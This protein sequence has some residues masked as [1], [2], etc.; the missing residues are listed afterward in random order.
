MI[1]DPDLFTINHQGTNTIKNILSR[2]KYK[3][4]VHI[5]SIIIPNINPTTFV[6]SDPE[7]S[8]TNHDGKNAKKIFKVV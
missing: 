4:S 2:V 7:L 1:S 5:F 8:T 3:K 6:I